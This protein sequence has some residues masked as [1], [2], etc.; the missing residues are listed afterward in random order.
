[1]VHFSKDISHRIF[2]EFPYCRRQK[3]FTGLIETLDKDAEIRTDAILRIAP[4][5]W[6]TIIKIGRDGRCNS[7]LSF[8]RLTIKKVS[9]DF[10]LSLRVAHLKKSLEQGK[11]NDV[12][13]WKVTQWFSSTVQT[14]LG[15]VMIFL[16]ITMFFIQ[17][18]FCLFEIFCSVYS[19]VL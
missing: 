2:S 11:R 18:S 6:I 9:V 15:I 4:S 13:A 3:M 14:T 5:V 19:R 1:M 8:L 7:T 12:V 16:R 10:S 17:C